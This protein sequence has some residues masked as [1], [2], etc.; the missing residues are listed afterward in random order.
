M[1]S[2]HTR[3]HSTEPSALSRRRWLTTGAL[4]LA[5]A[6]CAGQAAAQT[7]SSKPLR[8][9]VGYSAGGAV[10]AMAR[11]LA[12]GLAT[13]L[14]LQVVVEN[15]AGASGLIAA[16]L[17]SRSAADGH[18]L[19]LGESGLLIASLLQPGQR[20]DPLK[21]FAPV[22]GLFTTPLMIVAN[23]DFPARN[24][25]ELV[26]A[27][28]AKPGAYSYATSGLGTVHHLG[29]EMLKG[30]ANAFVV[31]IPYRGAA[32]IV[33]D[34]MSGQ[35][36]LGVVS[37]T[38]GIAQSKAGRLRALAMMSPVKL[39]G[40]EDVAPLSDAL[41]GFNVAPRL[42][43]LAPT[44]TPAAIVESLNNAVRNVLAKPETIR[45]ANAQGAVPAY[46]PSAELGPDLV[47]ES[48]Q[49]ADLI[50]TQKISIQ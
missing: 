39:A 48:A 7:L 49:W 38:A 25:R 42:V 4:G 11:L 46:L 1:T 33:P 31:H 17:V 36:P 2:L 40:A 16:D 3:I 20:L 43:L 30:Q 28:K 13:E 18:T 29:F 35:V 15:R 44:G 47:R 21:S 27:L 41:A 23:N 24:P 26:A 10:D 45:A 6:L 5:L 50:K 34:V 32:Q 12:Q 19:L 8:V 14:N 37:A 22:A 9:L